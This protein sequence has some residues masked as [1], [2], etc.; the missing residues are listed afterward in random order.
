LPCSFRL[1]CGHQCRLKCHSYDLEHKE[2][3]CKS[4]CPKVM[5]MC[6][7]NCKKQCGHADTCEPCSEFV[8]KKIEQC[9]H[10]VKAKCGD[11]EPSKLNC[12]DRCEKYL[13]ACGHR[14]QKQ[15]RE[16]PCEPCVALIQAKPV[17]K[18]TNMKINVKCSESDQL[19]VFQEKCS[20]PCSSTLECGHQCKAKCGECYG[21]YLHLPCSNDCDRL[22]NIKN[23]NPSL[24]FINNIIIF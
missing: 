21:G 5:A 10:Q 9:G 22:E 14:C 3:K 12:T 4:K 15:C 24:Y 16:E 8:M 19:W 1:R 23:Q 13:T 20:Q 11:K 7:H 18:H 17:C 2:Y 6:G